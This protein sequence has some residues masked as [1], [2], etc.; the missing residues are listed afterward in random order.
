VI[1]QTEAGDM[2]HLKLLFTLAV[3]PAVISLSFNLACDNSKTGVIQPKEVVQTDSS[4]FDS[5]VDDLVGLM[6]II[7]EP[8]DLDVKQIFP[9]GWIAETYKAKG[10]SNMIAL[11]VP[12]PKD[13]GRGMAPY[14]GYIMRAGL[15]DPN[16]NLYL[17][18][19]WDGMTYDWGIQ[20][21]SA[22]ER[23]YP[24]A[25]NAEYFRSYKVMLQPY[26]VPIE[27]SH[28]VY[29]YKFEVGNCY[30][31]KAS[32]LAEGL[33]GVSPYKSINAGT[34]TDNASYLASI[35]DLENAIIKINDDAGA[36]VN[37]LI[38]VK[39]TFFLKPAYADSK[40]DVL[41]Q[42]TD[43]LADTRTKLA[44]AVTF[45]DTLKT[46]DFSAAIKD[47]LGQKK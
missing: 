43:K 30:L 14:K 41:T 44:K 5:Y 22:E 39:R 47:K 12:I 46:W 26:M 18:S 29:E 6:A 1:K 4:R 31:A 21:R 10:V 3:I 13:I 28:G 7:Q 20:D 38:L 45:N 33:K 19:T 16:T 37:F 35:K 27:A 32:K 2:N 17:S 8:C 24:K 25:V 36:Y 42:Y 23:S 40:K 9:E 11:A 34:Y 15:L